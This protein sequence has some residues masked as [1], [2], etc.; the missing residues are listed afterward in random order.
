ML[1]FREEIELY[2][3]RQTHLFCVIG[4]AA[5]LAIGVL[6]L[7]IA[8]LEWSRLSAQFIGLH[9][10]LCVAFFLVGRKPLRRIHEIEQFT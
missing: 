1:T 8:H 7:V 6:W 10:V 2:R 3:L 4:W 9:A 5:N